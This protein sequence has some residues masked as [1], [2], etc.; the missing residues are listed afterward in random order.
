MHVTV[1]RRVAGGG[2]LEFAASFAPAS[3]EGPTATTALIEN[4][5]SLRVSYFGQDDAQAAKS[6]RKSWNNRNVLPALLLVEIE[7]DVDGSV[8]RLPI[9][10]RVGRQSGIFAGRN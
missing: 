2:R 10:A 5:T 9:Y 8:L 1:S 3:G 7:S 4:L 6:W